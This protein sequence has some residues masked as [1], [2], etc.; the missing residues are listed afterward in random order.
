[1]LVKG[2]VWKEKRAKRVFVSSGSDKYS[3]EETAVLACLHCGPPDSPMV[4]P[5]GKRK[6]GVRH[7]RLGS[8]SA[9]PNSNRSSCVSDSYTCLEGEGVVRLVYFFPP[10]MAI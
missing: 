4:P 10:W 7:V 2:L 5:G 9:K 1:M 3:R 8:T 6:K